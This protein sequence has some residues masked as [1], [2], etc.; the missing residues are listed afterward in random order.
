LTGAGTRI[1]TEGDSKVLS[2]SSSNKMCIGTECSP[3]LSGEILNVA[4]GSV[5]E[6]DG[7]KSGKDERSMPSG[8]TPSSSSLNSEESKDEPTED[9]GL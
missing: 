8:G 7:V 2:P 3:A 5:D 6:L 4:C 9:D 1:F